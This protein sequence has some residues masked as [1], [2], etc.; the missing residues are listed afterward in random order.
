MKKK[1]AFGLFLI[2]LVISGYLNFGKFSSKTFLSTIQE[3]ASI[4][5]FDTAHPDYTL[6]TYNNRNISKTINS[7]IDSASR[8]IIYDSKIQFYLKNDMGIGRFLPYYKPVS[9]N[10]EAIYRWEVIVRN[11]GENR[12]I[13]GNGKLKITGKSTVFGNISP[14]KVKKRVMEDVAKEAEKNINSETDKR[15]SELF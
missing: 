2:L 12:V 11:N 8:N 7:K 4:S 13:N 10:S 6:Y 15:I 5:F 3:N 9:I 1:L 14:N